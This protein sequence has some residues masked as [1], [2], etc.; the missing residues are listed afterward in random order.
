M[1]NPHCLLCLVFYQCPCHLNGGVEAATTLV[2]ALLSLLLRFLFFFLFIIITPLITFFSFS[3]LSLL[4]IFSS[5]SSFV[6]IHWSVLGEACLAVLSVLDAGS[7]FLSILFE[8]LLTFEG[9]FLTASLSEYFLHYSYY[10]HYLCLTLFNGIHYLRA[11]YTS[12][13]K[14]SDKKIQQRSIVL[15]VPFT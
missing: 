3:Y 9:V 5:F 12:A 15:Q 1:L 2:G 14:I 10:L 4:L 11:N 7:L 8:I 6:H 13:F